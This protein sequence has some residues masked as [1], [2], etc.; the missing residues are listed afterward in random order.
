MSIN[1]T[2]ASALTNNIPQFVREDYQSFVSFIQDVYAADE[3]GGRS[4]ELLR[5]IL[6]YKDVANYSATVPSITLSGYI[7]ET[8]TTITVTNGSSL[9]AANGVIQIDDEVILYLTRTNNTLFG[10]YRGATYVTSLG[11]LYT[12]STVSEAIA[13]HHHTGVAV[14]DLTKLVMV[15]FLESIYQQQAPTLTPDLMADTLNIAPVLSHIKSLYQS[16]GTSQAIETLFKI[17]YGNIEV[18]VVYP[19]DRVLSVSESDWSSRNS[20]KCR[21]L[22]GDITELPGNV[23]YQLDINGNVI[24]QALVEKLLVH[25]FENLVIYELSLNGSSISG[26]ISSVVTTP[27][28][29]AINSSVT[30]LDLEDTVG[31]PSRNGVVVIDDEEIRYTYKTANQLLDCVRGYNSTTAVAHD[32]NSYVYSTEYLIAYYTDV[33]GVEH[34]ITLRQMNCI[35]T[36][37]LNEV[38]RFCSPSPLTFG[39]IGEEFPGHPRVD[40]WIEN[41]QFT[42]CTINDTTI[43]EEIPKYTGGI[44]GVYSDVDNTCVISNSLPTHLI[45][46][47]GNIDCSG[48]RPLS[49]MFV[50]PTSPK[51]TGTYVETGYETTGLFLNG[52]TAQSCYT[53]GDIVSGAIIRVTVDDRGTGYVDPPYIVIEGDGTGAVLTPVLYRGGIY[54]FTITNGGQGFTEPPIIR[55]YSGQN[56]GFDAVLDE[57]GRLVSV[58]LSSAGEYY[59]TIPEAVLVDPTGRGAGALLEFTDAAVNGSGQLVPG[60]LRIL[61]R[62]IDYDP[63]SYIQIIPVGS[64]ASATA[65]IYTYHLDSYKYAN[66]TGGDY[67]QD[68][69]GGFVFQRKLGTKFIRCNY[70]YGNNPSALRT[71][72][73]DTSI[74]SHSPILGWAYDGN[75]IYG[76][77]G[78][79]LPLDSSSGVARMVSGYRLRGTR[80]GVTPPSTGTYPLGTF[81]EDYY[82]TTGY[83]HLDSHNGRYC[84]TPEYPDGVYAYFVTLTNMGTPAFPYIIG[85]TYRS[86]PKSQYFT[87]EAAGLERSVSDMINL[88]QFFYDEP[89]TTLSQRYTNSIKPLVRRYSS[90][91]NDVSLQMLAN[92][93]E[94]SSGSI[95]SVYVDS[96]EPNFAAGDLCYFQYD[97]TPPNECEAVVSWLSGAP[98]TSVNLA[99]PQVKIFL[100]QQLIDLGTFTFTPIP[101]DAA[102]GINATTNE[103]TITGHGLID[104]DIVVYEEVN[105]TT[106]TGLG[107]HVTYY[108][109]KIS[110]NVIKVAT[111]AANLANTIYVDIEAAGTGDR[112]LHQKTPYTFAYTDINTV[113]DTITLTAHGM[114][115]GMRVLYERVSGNPTVGVKEKTCYFVKVVDVD[116]IKLSTT[117][118]NLMNEVYVNFTAAGTGTRTLTVQF[119]FAL[120]QEV[121]A[122]NGC[123]FIITYWDKPLNR[124]YVE[125][126]NKTRLTSQT[127]FRDL[128]GATAFVIDGSL[129]TTN[130]PPSQRRL[131]VDDTSGLYTGDNIQIG[132]EV[133]KIVN[134]Y[135]NDTILVTRGNSPLTIED[136]AYVINLTRF[137]IVVNTTE[138]HN[139]QLDDVVSISGATPPYLNGRQTVAQITTD[140]EFICFVKLPDRLTSDIF[141]DLQPDGLAYITPMVPFYNTNPTAGTLWWSTYTGSLFVYYMDGTTNQWVSVSPTG[142]MP[143]QQGDITPSVVTGGYYSGTTSKTGAVI[144]ISNVAP[145][146]RSDGSANQEG[147]FWWSNLIGSLFVYFDGFWVPACANGESTYIAPETPTPGSFS[148]TSETRSATV[149]ISPDTPAGSPVSGD[150]WWSSITGILYIRYAGAWVIATPLGVIPGEGAEPV[151]VSDTQGTTL[152]YLVVVTGTGNMQYVTTSNNVTRAISIV[153]VTR[154]GSGLRTLP[155][156][157]GTIPPVLRRFSGTVILDADGGIT[158]VTISNGGARYYNP[159]IIFESETGSGATADIFVSGGVVSSIVML[160]PG[161]GYTE[162]T[163]VVMVESGCSLIPKSNDIGNIRAIAIDHSGYNQQ[164]NSTLGPYTTARFGA[165]VR[166][167]V[168]TFSP[169]TM[170]YVGDSSVYSFKAQ[171]YS[172]NATS[173]MLTLTGA[174]GYLYDGDALSNGVGTLLGYCL[175]SGQPR[176]RARPGVI[177][178]LAGTFQSSEH[179]IGEAFS[180]ITDSYYY[181]N[182]SYSIDSSIPTE[183]YRQVVKDTL[184]PAGYIMFGNL[185]INDPLSTVQAIVTSTIQTSGDDT[186]PE[187]PIPPS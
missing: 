86:L 144:Q 169:G 73:G 85:P 42:K 156:I 88:Q 161:S 152:D 23:V 70:S 53:Y 132:S 129:A 174:I 119:A 178:R 141:S 45:G 171:I 179:H 66:P 78:Y 138:P 187:D 91:Y 105:G 67:Y 81:I 76:P 172:Y 160:N 68:A 125:L 75:P 103:I 30:V 82:Y 153:T 175:Q 80:P 100:Q 97:Q 102:T 84:V 21:L 49:N 25:E 176:L 63:S 10:C 140:T 154:P 147:D 95:S 36:V 165:T 131:Y 90:Q 164:V 57:Y 158:G 3:R 185:T 9:P 46:G 61:A 126:T 163:N 184:H 112:V 59:S 136:N 24:G 162:E 106:S 11:D 157:I 139:L 122:E 107:D 41:T 31:L 151:A 20:M 135:E 101:F 34:T 177:T 77:Y 166:G 181:Q 183:N 99:V 48:L 94:T 12:A 47:F 180:K 148:G 6:T 4:L 96:S 13:T 22:A 5:G 17:L 127:V 145:G 27:L 115:D 40:S 186:P 149:T 35:N 109:K 116:T 28:V 33:E 56:G 121:E 64:G 182:F 2:V 51:T 29:T 173:K 1:P 134:V 79:N 92:I 39:H 155:S 16:K 26:T 7:S 37:D 52:V 104:G 120:D 137:A 87:L 18:D 50:I 93:T 114:Q 123:Q 72:L 32:V 143:N 74:S 43:Y 142:V 170:I 113:D 58:S 124:I 167:Q 60:T 69:S 146:T 38:G 89:S 150:L 108:V 128:V 110:N 98:V 71:L 111:S 168:E 14:V 133:M 118:N 19:G 83:G 130:I 117:L 8:A 65:E 54:R 44:T 62:G 55:I 159:I 15:K